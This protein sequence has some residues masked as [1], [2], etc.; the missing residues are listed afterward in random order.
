[1]NMY[2]LKTA[3]TP[4]AEKDVATTSTGLPRDYRVVRDHP[5]DLI[6]GDTASGIRTRSSFNLMVNYAFISILEP[7][8]VVSAL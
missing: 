1:M 8:D 5:K 7:K 2:K 3:S 6:L 4:Q